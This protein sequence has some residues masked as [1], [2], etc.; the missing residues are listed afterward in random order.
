MLRPVRAPFVALLAA[1]ALLCGCGDAER[2]DS[3]RVQATV[4]AFGKASAA[5]D[6]QRLCDDLLSP[7][8]VEDVEAAGLPC[9]VA[10]GQGL[11][12]VN[13]PSLTIGRIAVD[14]DKA[15]AEVKSTAAV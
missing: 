7:K 2:S 1:G 6:Y 14:G 15:T 4:E 5:K 3:E 10:M 9:E 13:A 8:L 12:E 11:G